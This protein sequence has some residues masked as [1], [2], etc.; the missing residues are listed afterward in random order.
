V[1]EGKAGVTISAL[2]MPRARLIRKSLAAVVW[3]LNL[4]DWGCAEPFL[5]LLRGTPF[6]AT[7]LCFDLI[8]SATSTCLAKF[9]LG[10]SSREIR[11]ASIFL[12]TISTLSPRTP[13]PLRAILCL[14]FVRALFCLAAPQIVVRPPT[15][16]AAFSAFES[17]IGQ[18]GGRT[19]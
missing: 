11:P 5:T 10:D 15:Q 13:S 3:A 9:E 1:N 12:L 14:W 6:S 18:P 2:R 8:L 19:A 4:G 7:C 17:W 16:V